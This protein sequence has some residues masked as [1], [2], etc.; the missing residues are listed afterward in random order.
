MTLTKNNIKFSLLC[1]SNQA[2]YLQSDLN[3]QTPKWIFAGVKRLSE[4]NSLQNGF[5][6]RCKRFFKQM[7]NFLPIIPFFF[8]DS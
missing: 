7:C 6:V 1:S 8:G 4:P 3:P 2:R 5:S